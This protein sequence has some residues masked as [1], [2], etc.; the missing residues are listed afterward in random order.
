[1]I[2]KRVEGVGAALR[3]LVDLGVIQMLDRSLR[4]PYGRCLDMPIEDKLLEE[5]I[6]DDFSKEGFNQ[7][8]MSISRALLYFPL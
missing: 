2:E 1:V 6:L 5:L 4:L 7:V 8:V 3:M